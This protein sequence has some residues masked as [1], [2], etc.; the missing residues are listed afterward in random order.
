MII[1]TDRRFNHVISKI[2]ENI[3]KAGYMAGFEAGVKRIAVVSPRQ[4]REAE[5]IIREKANDK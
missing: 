4:I 3:F 1:M 2:R 5:A